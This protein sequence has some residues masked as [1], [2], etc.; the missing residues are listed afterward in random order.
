MQEQIADRSNIITDEVFS[1][2][3]TMEPNTTDRSIYEYKKRKA[4]LLLE[5]EYLSK[6]NI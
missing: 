3:Q 1:E 2:G 6:K 5:K 4:I